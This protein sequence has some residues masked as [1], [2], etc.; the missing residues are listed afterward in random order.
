MENGRSREGNYGKE[1]TK[2]KKERKSDGKWDV[3]IRL[4]CVIFQQ[5]EGHFVETSDSFDHPLNVS[6]AWPTWSH[7][8]NNQPPHLFNVISFLNISCMDGLNMNCW[9]TSLL[10]IFFLILNHSSSAFFKYL[11]VLLSGKSY[12]R[13]DLLSPHLPYFALC[14]CN[15]QNEQKQLGGGKG[16]ISSSKS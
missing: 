6:N 3:I 1:K 16:F 12:L 5:L 9:I 13:Q 4:I 7:E 11:R 14:G 8:A 2:F 15:K 10:N